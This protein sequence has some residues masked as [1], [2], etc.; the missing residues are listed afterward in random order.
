MAQSHPAPGLHLPDDGRFSIEAEVVEICQRE[1][2]RWA[3]VVLR[4]ATVV[5]MLPAGADLHL[6][7]HVELQCA[8]RVEHVRAMPGRSRPDEG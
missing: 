3:R 2:E 1:D 6:G 5:Q 8:I 4:G 7:D